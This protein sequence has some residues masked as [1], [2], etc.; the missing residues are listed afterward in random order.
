M[1][2][3]L[4]NTC[5]KFNLNYIDINYYSTF[6]FNVVSQVNALREEKLKNILHND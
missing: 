5:L 3:K 6:E 2:R 1:L 4:K